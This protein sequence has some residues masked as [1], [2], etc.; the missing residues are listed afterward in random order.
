[1]MHVGVQVHP[2]CRLRGAAQKHADDA[3][4][5][6][7]RSL[8]DNSEYNILPLPLQFLDNVTKRYFKTLQ[9]ELPTA[10]LSS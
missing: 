4:E 8:H 6:Q 7:L 3:N 9:T 1:M 2:Y 5:Q 10:E